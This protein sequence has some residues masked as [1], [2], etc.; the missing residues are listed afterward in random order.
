MLCLFI[1]NWTKSEDLR[2]VVC[3]ESWWDAFRRHE[4]MELF[5][6][7]SKEIMANMQ[8]F[9]GANKFVVDPEAEKQDKENNLYDE[10]EEE[11]EADEYDMDDRDPKKPNT[12]KNG[13]FCLDLHEDDD[14]AEEVLAANLADPV[15]K[16][17]PV[18]SHAHHILAFSSQIGKRLAPFWRKWVTPPISA[19]QD[20]VNTSAFRT[21]AAEMRKRKKEKFSGLKTLV[22]NSTS[23]GSSSAGSAALPQRFP[24]DQDPSKWSPL[25]RADVYRLLT[26]AITNRKHTIPKKSGPDEAKGSEDVL[27]PCDRPSMSQHSLDWGLNLQQ[28]H[29]FVYM[30]AAILEVLTRRMDT[31]EF[32]PDRNTI[33]Q[34]L[35]TILSPDYADR[36]DID[37][38]NMDPSLVVTN[39][40][41][42]YMMGSAGTGK[43][44]VFKAV[45]DFARR[46]NMS[47]CILRT[48]T[49]G[50]S[51]ALID[52]CTWFHGLGVP[53]TLNL[54]KQNFAALAKHWSQIGVLCID[55]ISMMSS[56]QLYAI[57]KRLRA[58]KNHKLPFGGV[59]VI[60]SGDLCQYSMT[61]NGTLWK[62]PISKDYGLKGKPSKE[63]DGERISEGVRKW[64]T[65]FNNA[66]ELTQLV[67]QAP[68]SDFARGLESMKFNEHDHGFI[69]LANERVVKT[70]M[71][72]EL[73]NKTVVAVTSHK[74]RMQGN[75][76]C[77]LSRCAR[78]PVLDPDNPGDWRKRGIIRIDCSFTSGAGSKSNLCPRYLRQIR[79][80]DETNLNKMSGELYFIIGDGYRVTHNLDV[81]RKIS[82]GTCASAVDVIFVDDLPSGAIKFEKMDNAGGGVHV[83][84]AAFIQ[85]L[86]LKHS[87]KDFEKDFYLPQDLLAFKENCDNETVL[88]QGV[89]PVIGISGTVR[90]RHGSSEH[91][92][93]ANGFPVVMRA[94]V[95]GHSTQGQTIEQ[96][97]IANWGKETTNNNGYV[98]MLLS[99][100]K[101]ISQ[102]L[103]LQPLS[104]DLSKYV[105]RADLSDELERIR[106]F[107]CTKSS[108]RLTGCKSS[109]VQR[110]YMPIQ[111]FPTVKKAFIARIMLATTHLVSMKSENKTKRKTWDA[112]P[113]YR[114]YSKLKVGDFVTFNTSHKMKGDPQTSLN[115]RITRIERTNTFEALFQIHG[116][117]KFLPNGGK[118][119][120]IAEAVRL[121]YAFKNYEKQE[122]NHGVVGFEFIVLSDQ[123]QFFG[124]NY[125]VID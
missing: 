38:A 20:E 116:V 84:E 13:D 89:F 80:V 46:W 6:A 17:V 60:F 67:R 86:L 40:L 102:L 72:V 91:K 75:L 66:I 14:V 62:L 12:N 73:N 120:T 69:A 112:R 8:G 16:I 30:S 123:R 54:K 111:R 36:H 110:V 82:N 81:T 51:A 108:D 88:P 48:A 3:K 4:L 109:F 28:H 34:L 93:T 23:S 100:V 52:G 26:P 31:T 5:S 95:T 59:H 43:T 64:R 68:D 65:Y 29:A 7:Q 117:R 104:G 49:T 92:L 114:M 56:T 63:E 19:P 121:Y 115:V 77:A 83:V 122:T 78:T 87:S 15:E 53:I 41:R 1:P 97:I 94:V 42:M 27:L 79:N 32:H 35:N 11:D 50:T 44:H 24:D 37:V 57:D 45:T 2:N 10:E 103:M 119:P 96:L 118:V 33:K 99:R 113:N 58:L 61:K 9:H 21:S 55:E 25:Q 106:K 47:S 74:D 85:G 107:V 22:G 39:T 90:A 18:V 101:K 124:Q 70:G 98:Y 105:R 125:V 76:T 71:V